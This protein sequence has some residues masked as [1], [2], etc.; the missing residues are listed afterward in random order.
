MSR[1]RGDIS[2]EDIARQFV[3][4]E[5]QSKIDTLLRQDGQAYCICRSSDSSRFM[6]ACDAC[7]EWYHGDCIKI[8]EKEAKLIRQY[9]CIRCQEEDPSLNTRWK[10]K[11]EKDEASVQTNIDDRKS[12]KRKERSESKPDKK[13][14]KK[15][16]ECMGCYRTEDCGRCD[17]CVRKNRHG[18][19]KTKERCKQRIC[20]NALGGGARRKRRDS[21]SDMEQTFNEHL[22]TDYPRQCYGQKCVRS[23]RYGSKYCSDQCGMNLAKTRILQVLPQR[24]QEWALSPSAAE[25]LNIKALDQVRKQQLEVREILHELD[26]RHRE[27]DYLVD[28]AKSATIDPNSE[29][30]VEKDEESSMYC[31]TCGHEI[32]SKTAVKHMEKCFNKYESQASF[33]SVFK[34]RIEGNNMFCDYYNPI[35]H[36]YC[37]RLRVL[38]PEHCKDPKIGDHEV[39][40]CPLVTNVFSPTGEFCR[41][42]KKS[43][44]RHYVWEKLRRAEVDLERVR[45]W[46][47]MDELLEKERQ[48]RTSMANR[49]GVLALM[50]H[51]TYN[52]ELMERI[53]KAQDQQSMQRE[54]E[55][56]RA[57]PRSRYA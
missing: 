19:S 2:K 23:A 45:Q 15:C 25:E 52:H 51:S 35:S 1:R 44:T 28:R 10:T 30:D 5:R 50:L 49:A 3:L 54:M 57:K 22:K 55:Q 37:K 16:G 26:K 36:T 56:A 12:K 46:L 27:I 38:C 20:I 34:T 17:V 4:P 8:S 29:Y 18:S 7:E 31:V 33:G 53:T 32:H 9:F 39:C 13:T 24:L 40:G 41:A 6:I 11:R 42:P 21:G 47:R 48:I 14:K 43:C